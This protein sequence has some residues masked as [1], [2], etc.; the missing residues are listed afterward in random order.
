MHNGE[1]NYGGWVTVPINAT[2][3]SMRNP[4][5]GATAAVDVT[6]S[7]GPVEAACLATPGPQHV[8][9]NGVRP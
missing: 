4:Q 8:E 2:R 6:D 9:R 7:Y 3:Y 5:R 1:T